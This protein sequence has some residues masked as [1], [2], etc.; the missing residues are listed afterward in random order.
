MILVKAYLADFI[1]AWNMLV[2]RPL[3]GIAGAPGTGK[4]A[5]GGVLICFPLIGLLLGSLTAGIALLAQAALSRFA[6]AFV[7][8][9]LAGALLWLK[10]SGRG[11]SMLISYAARRFSGMESFR[12][13]E[14]ASPRMENFPASPVVMMFSAVGIV[15]LLGMLF[16][17]FY[18]GAGLWFP[19]VLIADTFVQA[20]LCL[21]PDRK[22]GEPFLR[23]PGV[24][25]FLYLAVE[26]IVFGV[27]MLIIFPR[28]AALG[29]VVIIWVW[30][31]RELPES[32][33]FK[34]GIA[35]DWISLWGSW[36]AVLMLV[37]GMGLL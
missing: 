21:L 24:R 15:G 27:L 36:A 13:L 33:D 4:A 7:F 3:S 16:A 19:A 12:A 17:L 31:W 29:A 28:I 20:R 37:C 8:M 1:A 26:G 35:S 30:F 32:E 10:D 23:I 25:E 18:R 6:G 34:Q 14:A 9:I 2:D 5:P 22:T 11:L